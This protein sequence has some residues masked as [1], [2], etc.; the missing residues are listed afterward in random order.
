[1]IY[2]YEFNKIFKINKRMIISEEEENQF[3]STN[4]CMYCNKVFE[5]KKVRDHCHFTG[6]YR[7][8]SCSYM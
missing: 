4:N 7:G 3:Q 1:M 6:K 2:H 8:A 5:N